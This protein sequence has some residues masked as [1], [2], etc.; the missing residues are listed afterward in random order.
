MGVALQTQRV[1]GEQ[2]DYP[3]IELDDA[4][5][6]FNSLPWEKDIE[7]WD[8]IPEDK[9]EEFRPIFH[10]MDDSEHSLRITAYSPDLIVLSYDYSVISRMTFAGPEFEQ[11][12]VA[13]A[14]FP[15]ASIR[16]LLT[17]FFTS[18]EESMLTLLRRYPDPEI[19][20]TDEE[21]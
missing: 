16:E 7:A 17:L 5:V 12:Y 2:Y 9:R 1:T 8:D 15:R 4:L 6:I 19:T 18:N 10:L 14:Q 21:P 11:R 20:D 3:A 13:T